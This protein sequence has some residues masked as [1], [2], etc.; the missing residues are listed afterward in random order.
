MLICV[1]SFTVVVSVVGVSFFVVFSCFD[2][3]GAN[4]LSKV[5]FVCEEWAGGAICGV[6][7]FLLLFC[8]CL[9]ICFAYVRA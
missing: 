2:V 1:F 9:N 7:V 8:C 4:S 5:D 6:V 3:S